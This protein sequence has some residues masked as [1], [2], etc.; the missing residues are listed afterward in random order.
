MHSLVA[1]VFKQF[2]LRGIYGNEKV[3]T[4]Y[5]ANKKSVQKFRKFDIL[6]LEE[7]LPAN[8]FKLP[9][10]ILNNLNR[11]ILN[12]QQKN[13]PDFAVSDFHISTAHDHCFDW[14]VLAEKPMI[15]GM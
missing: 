12:R 7:W 6:R 13:N 4:Y 1:Q 5:E 14:L 8:L 2:E 10:N 9:Y 11:M 3:M 15:N